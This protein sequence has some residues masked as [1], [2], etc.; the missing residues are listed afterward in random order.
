[1]YFARHICPSKKMSMLIS[2]DISFRN[3]SFPRCPAAALSNVAVRARV[4]TL[5]PP[6][7][8]WDASGSCSAGDHPTG[9]PDRRPGCAM[10]TFGPPISSPGPDGLRTQPCPAFLN[11]VV[12]A[13]QRPQPPK[14]K[15]WGLEQ[16]ELW[17]LYLE[18]KVQ[19][20]HFHRNKSV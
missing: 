6:I 11:G 5:F 16:M 20:T 2:A 19:M 8:R 1:M 10:I 3:T 17:R 18:G 14:E 7:R 15:R 13:Q 4:C 12:E 9:P